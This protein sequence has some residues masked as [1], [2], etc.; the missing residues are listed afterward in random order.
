MT[1]PVRHHFVPQMIIRNFTDE[2]GWLHGWDMKR[3]ARGVFRS[4]PENVFFE[5][6]LYSIYDKAG[7]MVPTAESDLS[8]LEG[9]IGPIIRKIIQ[10]ARSHQLPGLSPTERA[11]WDL[12]FFVQWKR[13]P[14]QQKTSMTDAALLEQFDVICARLLRDHP[15]RRAEIES[16][17]SPAKR[18]QMLKNVRVGTVVDPGR[19]VPEALA[20][21]GLTL[22]TIP[23]GHRSF[24]LGSRPV[25]K[26]NIRGAADLT[27]ERSEVW[28]PIAP[29]VAVG[30][31]KR[32]QWEQGFT[33][34]EA[35][36][37]RDLNEATWGQ[38]SMVVGRSPDL[39][40][41]LA[42]RR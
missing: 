9:V 2:H 42:S 30:P 8:R 41:S 29:D 6:H 13:V 35:K 27:D 4:R 21:R 37:I 16:L 32:D 11:W 19:R 3:P 24:L 31:G 39:V 12:F 1:N 20:S 17:A 18:A 15:E 14:D 7:A 36:P 28:L 34:E 22:L 26:L 23:A 33:L 5:N 40:R 38:S 25:V 10:A